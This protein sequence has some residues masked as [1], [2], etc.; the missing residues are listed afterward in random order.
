MPSSER[1][2]AMSIDIPRIQPVITPPEASHDDALMVHK[3]APTQRIEEELGRAH[4]ERR[5]QPERRRRRETR[6]ALDM[7][8]GQQRRG[9]SGTVID[10][11]V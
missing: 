2:G 6:G 7:R 5:S 11:E 1:E 4:L 3:T 9:N 8:S 10:V